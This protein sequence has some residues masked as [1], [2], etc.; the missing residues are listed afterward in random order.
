MRAKGGDTFSVD[1]HDEELPKLCSAAA[2]LLE[3]SAKVKLLWGD[4]LVWV[5]WATGCETS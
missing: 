3:D 5:V 1:Y 2:L 4:S